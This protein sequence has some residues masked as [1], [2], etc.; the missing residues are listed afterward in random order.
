MDTIKCL[1]HL[2]KYGQPQFS[3][4]LRDLFA[5]PLE[6]QQQAL[7]KPLFWNFYQY[8]AVGIDYECTQCLV[9]CPVGR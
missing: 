7:R 3:K 9:A 5:K 1:L 4:F 8:L 2:Q 6:E